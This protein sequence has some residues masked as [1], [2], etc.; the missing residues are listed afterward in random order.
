M[1][2]V[3]GGAWNSKSHFCVY[4]EDIILWNRTIEGEIVKKFH[5][6]AFLE[7]TLVPILDEEMELM[8]TQAST[9]L[10]KV[11]RE[12]G[13]DPLELEMEGA[14]TMTST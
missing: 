5:G 13:Y 12:L 6:I 8:D 9:R 7:V 4:H 10:A 3:A 2:G 14:S 11:G 1:A